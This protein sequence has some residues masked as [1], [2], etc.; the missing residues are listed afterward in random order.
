MSLKVSTYVWENSK[1]KG[2]GLLLMLAIADF[3]HDDGGGSYPSIATLAR[4]ARTTER[5]V[6][7]LLGKLEKSG[8][9]E[10]RRNA[11]PRR[12][13]IYRV[14]FV[15][16][17]YYGSDDGSINGSGELCFT[18]DAHDFSPSEDKLSP[19]ARRRVQQL[20]DI[21]ADV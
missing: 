18:P 2:T 13:N 3:A 6:K 14:K 17:T 10:V 21:G 4:K 19:S 5:N 20:R 11:G 9:L 7:I 15:H 8:E 1:Q 12:T 16:P